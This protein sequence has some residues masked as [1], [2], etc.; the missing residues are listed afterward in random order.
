MNQ[1]DY[2]HIVVIAALYTLYGLWHSQRLAN[3]HRIRLTVKQF[4][5]L[6]EFANLMAS[7]GHFDFFTVYQRMLLE[8]AFDIT[9]FSSPFM[10]GQFWQ[11]EQMVE[12]D[13]VSGHIMD[14]EFHKFVSFFLVHYYLH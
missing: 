5:S 13:E 10:L 3:K 1:K 9:M 12:V 14:D 7:Q 6:D 11:R 4:A 8:R 2:E